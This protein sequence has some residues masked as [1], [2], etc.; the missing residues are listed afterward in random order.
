MHNIFT[1]GSLMFSPVWERVV[2]GQYESQPAVLH[3]YQRLAVKYEEYPVAIPCQP[4][5]I[6]GLLYL[7]VNNEDLSRLDEFEGDYYARTAV[8]LLVHHKPM[9][10]YV[11]VL[12]DQYKNIASSQ[13]WDVIQ[14]QKQGINAFL[15]RYKGFMSVTH[16]KS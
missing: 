9:S 13:P 2:H 15:E 16:H 3:G 4:C 1:Y 6:N 5:S 10:G 11:Y 7:N 12:K 14:F 8:T